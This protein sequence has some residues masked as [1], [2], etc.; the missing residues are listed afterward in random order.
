METENKDNETLSASELL[1]KAEETALRLEQANKESL[2]ILEAQQELVARKLLGGETNH[3]QTPTKKEET[4][5]E[6]AKRILSGKV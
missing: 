3:I 4:S 1:K 2:R 5:Q 6:Y